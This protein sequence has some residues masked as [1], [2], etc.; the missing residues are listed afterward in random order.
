MFPT[1]IKMSLLS[2]TLLN[3]SNAFSKENEVNSGIRDV[4]STEMSD[5]DCLVYNLYHESRGESDIAN[6]MVL[7]T[8]L[9]RANSPHFP[10]T[11]CGVVKQPY[12]YSWTND[13]RSDVMRNRVQVDRLTKLVDNYLINKNVY[14]SVSQGVDHYH[15]TNIKPFWSKS[16]RME[17]VAVI[18]NH[19]FYRRKE[20]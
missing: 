7:N 11:I 5:R 12:Q 19:I 15:T 2:L 6:V 16:E 3:T 9:N 1:I 10:N 14:L 20:L 13:G 18:D 4:V 17:M 8:V